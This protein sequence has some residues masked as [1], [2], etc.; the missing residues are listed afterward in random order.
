MRILVTTLG[1]GQSPQNHREAV[2][3]NYQTAQY[4]FEEGDSSQPTQFFGLALYRHLVETGWKPDK[5][6]VL[7]TATSMWDAWLESAPELA[8]HVEFAGELYELQKPGNNGVDKDGLNRL[9][10]ILS[11]HY[12]I[13]F[14]CQIIPF[15][16]TPDEQ[17][18]ILRVLD[19]SVGRGDEVVLDVTHG[20]RHM[21][22]LELLSS[23]LLRHAKNVGTKAIYYGALDMPGPAGAK[24]VVRLDALSGLENWIEAVAVLESSGNVLPLA[25]A[26]SCL[27]GGKEVQMNL[28]RYQFLSEMN[29]MFPLRS[30]AKIISDW[31]RTS[32]PASA[33][34]ALF[35]DILLDFFSWHSLSP[36]KGQ[37]A[38]AERALRTGRRDKAVMMAFESVITA[39]LATGATPTDYMVR[40]N[41]EKSIP[42][43]LKGK[44]DTDSWWL[45]KDLRNSLAHGTTAGSSRMKKEINGMRSNSQRFSTEMK[46]LFKWVEKEIEQHEQR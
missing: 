35:Q 12:H 20:F 27:P 3:G 22:M 34:L 43:V 4:R 24:L 46:R 25:A 45:L 40:E 11:E 16:R 2:H 33:T 30:T 44:N 1:K 32:A 23:F 8:E 21:P 14:D 38:L 39:H 29:E 19:G 28:E 10:G 18:V 6:V 15:G 36:A 13:A 26:C 31:I 17:A 37:L 42:Q 9:S 5:I 7:G 41:T